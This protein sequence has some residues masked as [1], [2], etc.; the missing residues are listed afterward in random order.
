MSRPVSLLILFVITCALPSR[1]QN[2]LL[3]KDWFF[4]KGDAIRSKSLQWMPAQVPGTVHTDLFR[5]K[6]IADPYYGNVEKSLQWIENETWSYRNYFSLPSSLISS[7]SL[8]IEFEGLDTYASVYLNGLLLLRADNMF[9]NW[10]AEIR[11]KLVKGKNELVVVFSPSAVEAK[12]LKKQAEQLTGAVYP[13]S[14]RVFVRKAQYQF[15]WDWG[16][17]YVSCGIWKNVSIHSKKSATTSLL[18]RRNVLLKTG[19]DAWGSSFYFT[20]N[21]KPVYVRGANW[22]PADHFAP[23]ARRLKLYDSLLLAAK[24]AGIN[25]LRVWG[26]GIYEDDAFYDLCD[27]YEIMVWQDFMFAGALYPGDAA[28]LENVE[29]EVRYQVNRLK[30]HPSIVIWC[31]NN[32]IEEAWF[33]WGWQKQYN[34]SGAD[35]MRLWSDYKKIF[36]EM[37]PGILAEL[38]PQRPYWPSSPSLGWGREEAYRKGDVHYWG[39]WWGKEPIEQYREKTGRFVS[40]YGMQGM[41]SLKSIR[42]FADASQLDTSSRVMKAHQKHPFGWENIGLYIRERYREPRNFSDLVYTSQL[43]QAEA[44]KTA[45]E[46]HRRRKPFNMGTLFWQWNDCW[47][48]TSWSAVDY[49]G[50]KKALFYEVKRSFADVSIIPHA[51][52]SYYYIS[53]VSEKDSVLHGRLFTDFIAFNRKERNVLRSGEDISVGSSA[54]FTARSIRD[55]KREFPFDGC[56]RVRFVVNDSTLAENF[57]FLAPPKKLNL[58]KPKITVQ[59]SG[60]NIILESDVFA[61]GVEV[62]VPDDVKLDDNYF[63]LLPGEK[64][65]VKFYSKRPSAELLKLL[66]TKSLA[67]TY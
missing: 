26:G 33:N 14:E 56:M 2:L 38:D 49:F 39:V 13:E 30:H 12:R 52:S 11:R 31:G 67:D 47:P 24:E 53:I 3:V 23:R 21:G 51:D 20:E 16:P 58:A 28:F 35:S 34:Y 57:L 59:I 66:K 46:S 10:E 40:E 1:A 62:D 63:H 42:Q 32:E 6:K 17:R 60:T 5:N 43:M 64:K 44:I 27:K 48:V 61:Y 4:A 36:H 50:R 9:K 19:E 18:P 8:F 7:D 55:M 22:I 37:I 54:A 65:T 41:P 25:M 15:G 45:I 29:A